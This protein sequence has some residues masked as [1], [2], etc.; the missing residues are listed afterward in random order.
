MA[1]RVDFHKLAGE[2]GHVDAQTMFVALMAEYGSANQVSAALWCSLQ[3]LVRALVSY[4]WTR[5]GST[6]N[7]VWIAPHEAI[8]PAAGGGMTEATVMQDERCPL[9]HRTPEEA[10]RAKHNRIWC[11]ACQLREVRAGKRQP[12]PDAPVDDV[13]VPPSQRVLVVDYGRNTAMEGWFVAGA[14]VP[15][16]KSDTEY[17]VLV[18]RYALVLVKE[19]L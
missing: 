6:S 4:G 19:M 1:K 15:L 17:K 9:C 13:L 10:E 16:P 18:R 14:D 11:S 7:T 3:V 5:T 2:R 12:V 8:E